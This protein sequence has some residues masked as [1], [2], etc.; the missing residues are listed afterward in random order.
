MLTTVERAVP[1]H[2]N[3]SAVDQ[4]SADGSALELYAEELADCG[5]LVLHMDRADLPAFKFS[6]ILADSLAPASTESHMLNLTCTK[7]SGETHSIVTTTANYNDL[8]VMLA[9]AVAKHIGGNSADQPI[10]EV[11]IRWK[12]PIGREYS[13]RVESRS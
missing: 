6:G 4:P 2:G 1:A 7:N 3:S 9:E 12:A 10:E 8:Q 5:G 13:Y 11:I